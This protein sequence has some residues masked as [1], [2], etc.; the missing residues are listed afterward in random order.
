M[1]Y[2]NYRG[3]K[4]ALID[5]STHEELMKYWTDYELLNDFRRDIK[6]PD[7][8]CTNYICFYLEDGGYWDCIHVMHGIDKD[9]VHL[10]GCSFKL[11]EYALMWFEA[12]YEEDDLLEMEANRLKEIKIR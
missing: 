9:E 1:D 3:T 6:I 11:L 12:E 7:P 8:E 5:K 4:I 2:V 10:F